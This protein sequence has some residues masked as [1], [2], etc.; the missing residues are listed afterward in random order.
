M[1]KLIIICGGIVLAGIGGCKSFDCG[2]PM[3]SN[4]ESEVRGQEK[5]THLTPDSCR[6]TTMNLDESHHH[7]HQRTCID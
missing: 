2:C 3:T 7:Y 4:Q 1:K 6:L 5:T